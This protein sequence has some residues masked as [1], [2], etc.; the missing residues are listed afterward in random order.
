MM[1]TREV[2]RDAVFRIIADL[3]DRRGLRQAFESIDDDI[4]RELICAWVDMVNSAIRNVSR[5]PWEEHQHKALSEFMK[6]G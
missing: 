3:T 6:E 2:A 4:R 5:T 1:D